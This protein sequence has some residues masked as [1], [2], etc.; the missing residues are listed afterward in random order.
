MSL[1]RDQWVEMWN[2]I[3]GIERTVKFCQEMPR[4]QRATTLSKIERIKNQIQSV[5]GQ[6]E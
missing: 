3:K 6:M 2:D 5:I 1:T 4:G